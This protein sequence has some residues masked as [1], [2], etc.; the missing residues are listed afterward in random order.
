MDKHQASFITN[1]V[2]S[3][4]DYRSEWNRRQEQLAKNLEYTE[5]MISWRKA[6]KPRD[7]TSTRDKSWARVVTASQCSSKESRKCEEYVCGASGG[8]EQGTVLGNSDDGGAAIAAICNT[9]PI[10]DVLESKRSCLQLVPVRHFNG[11]KRTLPVLQSADSSAESSSDEPANAYFPCRWFYTLYGQR[12]PQD[13]LLCQG[14]PYWFPRPPVELNPKYWE[15][16]QKMLR[17]VTGEERIERPDT[18]LNLSQASP[19]AKTLWEKLQG[20]HGSPP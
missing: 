7:Y 6:T 15:T 14:C 10:P 17:I 13:A 12:Q 1:A 3:C 11:G 19:P 8:Y 18:Q 20:R 16:T 9:C 4:F 2:H 5:D